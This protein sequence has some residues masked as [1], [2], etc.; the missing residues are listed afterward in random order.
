MSERASYRGDALLARLLSAAGIDKS[1]QEVRDLIEGVNASPLPLASSEWLPLVGER[2]EGEL[3]AQLCAL[4][5]GLAEP[6]RTAEAAEI[7]ARVVAL[8]AELARRG[9]SGFIVPRADEH[10][11]EYVAR[12]SERLAWI[13]GFTGSAG[14]AI[15]LQDQAVILVDGRYTLQVRNEVPTGLYQHG[16][17]IETPPPEWLGRNLT[18]KARL[19]YDP[20]L[21]TA[22]A[23]EKLR[24]AVARADAE[25]VACAENPLDSVWLGQPPAPLAPVVAQELSFAGVSS[26][27]KRTEIAAAVAR[28]GSGAVALTQPDSVAWLLNIR[29]GDVPHTPFALSF[30]ILDCQGAV[31]WFVDRRK[32]V[33]GLEEHLGN[34]VA[35]RPPEE[36]G[37][38]LDGLAAAGVKVQIDPATAPSWIFDRL[39]GAGARI[40]RGDDP[41]SL[42]KSC[43][44]AVELGGTRAAHLRDAVAMVRFLAWLDSAAPAG[45]VTEMSAAAQLL[46]FRRHGAQ[47]RDLSFETISGA[48]P[49]GAI[50]HYRVSARS[51]RRLTPGSLYLV[52]SGAQYRDGTTDVTRTIAIGT[53]SA[54]MRRRFTLVLKGHIALATVR[55][56]VGTTGSQLDIL[57]RLPLW[58]EGLDYDHGTGHGVGSFLS[59]HEGPQRISK[60]PNVIALAPGMILSNEPGYYKAGAYGIRIEN[61]VVVTPCPDPGP[62]EAAGEREMLAFETLTLVPI[63]ARLIDPA[64]LTQA[65]I[66]WIDGYHARVRQTLLPLLG[67]SERAWLCHNTESLVI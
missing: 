64:L 11:G 53:P 43:K 25:L 18:A 59:V 12:R 34:Q 57:A 8:R 13:S 24:A 45:D 49:N 4:R 44:N 30:A 15:I 42:P 63:D 9:L 67:D 22:S 48:G 27:D 46:Q 3:A 51:D 2:V 58:S 21:H 40:E 23:V 19:G 32:L 16:H 6:P 35:I 52:D 62:G 5:T 55:F 37:A 17:L 20:W 26:Q 38:V 41:C 10:Q 28:T 47:F 65:E 36:L 7:G 54:E 33:P 60:A 1:T 50:N 29:G 61:L 66:A 56:P 39:S 31:D 14:V